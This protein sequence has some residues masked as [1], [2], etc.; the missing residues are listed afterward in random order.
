MK[1]AHLPGPAFL[2]AALLVPASAGTAPALAAPCTIHASIKARGH[3]PKVDR[4]WTITVTASPRTRTHAKYQFLFKGHVVST[5]YVLH[6]PHYAFT[7]RYRDPLR[8][9]RRAAGIT[10]TLRVV[11][12]NRCGTRNVDWKVTP[13]L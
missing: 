3:T 10:L 9:P 4:D 1:L 7:G 5:Q 12:T 8:F 2:V 13:R 11:L 6:N